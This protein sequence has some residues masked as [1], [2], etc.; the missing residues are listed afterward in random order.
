MDKKEL[1]YSFMCDSEYRPMKFKDIVALLQVP[2]EEVEVLGLCLDE[3]AYEYKIFKDDN[4]K[5]I[6][7]KNSD[8]VCGTFRGS[9][10]GFG[11]LKCDDEKREDV[12]IPAGSTNTALNDDKVI[13]KITDKYRGSSDEGFVYKILKR[14]NQYVVGTV[15]VNKN[16]VF[17]VPD[18]SK[19]NTDIYIKNRGKMAFR[20]GMKFLAFQVIMR[21]KFCPLSV[22]IKFVTSLKMCL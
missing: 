13:V 3:L 15:Q 21:Q 8:F 17:V 1:V 2:E 22:K 6:C 9:G 14:N 10:K 5:Y 12:Y 16:I 7:F 20:N 4:G 11:F 18:N 19:L